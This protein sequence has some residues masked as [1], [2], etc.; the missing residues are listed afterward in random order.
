MKKSN[1]LM[2]IIAASALFA[3]SE[4]ELTDIREKTE[5]NVKEIET[6]EDD[7]RAKEE[8]IFNAPRTRRKEIAL[9]EGQKVINEKLN[10][11]AWNLFTKTNQ[12]VVIT[13]QSYPEPD[14]AEQ[15]SAWTI[16]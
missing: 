5:E 6:V 1:Y 12:S 15:R 4:V 8:D 13:L 11:F 10:T 7:L 9:D 14:D 16:A 3:C 2:G